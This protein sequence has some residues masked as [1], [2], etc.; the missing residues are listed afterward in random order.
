M[1]ELH[2]PLDATMH[3]SVATPDSRIVPVVVLGDGEVTQLS[4]DQKYQQ[5]FELFSNSWPVVQLEQRSLGLVSEEQEALQ[6]NNKRLSVLE[7]RLKRVHLL[8]KQTQSERDKVHAQYEHD[9]GKQKAI[10]FR[11]FTALHLSIIANK[12]IPLDSTER[13]F[14]QAHGT[15]AKIRADI[16]QTTATRIE[17]QNRFSGQRLELSQE[18]LNV[19]EGWVVGDINRVLVYASHNPTRAEHVFG[20]FSQNSE[21]YSETLNFLRDEFGKLNGIGGETVVVPESRRVKT[22]EKVPANG[23]KPIVDAQDREI[24]EPVSEPYAVARVKNVLGDGDHLRDVRVLDEA[25]LNIF[26]R[27]QANKIVRNNPDVLRDIENM[28]AY[29]RENPYG[30]GTEMLTSP[31]KTITIGGNKQR[32]WHLIAAKSGNSL[33]LESKISYDLRVV[34]TVVNNG[35]A[36]N[37]LVLIGVYPH[38][39]FDSRFA[40]SSALKI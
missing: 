30:T 24:K 7:G 37:T 23:E 36:E 29:L 13:D 32:L 4:P 17:I 39:K 18:K 1:V 20:L 21:N 38:P 5:D 22:R 28:V 11:V 12:I 25:R 40:H 35:N 33:S 19:V 31:G 8:L 9:Y 26:L 2:K 3:D 16:D 14:Q 15:V 6:K 10:F 34:Y 27:R